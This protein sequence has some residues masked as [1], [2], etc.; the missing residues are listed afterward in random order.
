M[1]YDD[2]VNIDSRVPRPFKIIDGRKW[3]LADEEPWDDGE[4]EDLD[5]FQ[6]PPREVPFSVQLAL[7]FGSGVG[8]VFGTIFAGFALFIT[9]VVVCIVGLED[10]IPRRWE[11]AV[12]GKVVK[13]EKMNLEI[14]NVRYSRYHLEGTA[15]D[16]TVLRGS[17]RQPAGNHAEGDEVRM[18]HSGGHVRIEGTR[19]VYFIWIFIG[20]ALLFT[21]IGLGVSSFSMLSGLKRIRL[22]RDGTLS[23]A[24]II[25]SEPTNVRINH[26][27]VMKL[28][29][30]YTV[31]GQPYTA[32]FRT[33]EADRL[34]DSSAKIAF[35]D[36]LDP[37][38]ALLWESLPGIRVDEL[39]GRFQAGFAR[40]LL[41]M[42]LGLI[43]LAELAALLYFVAQAFV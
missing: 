24:H 23:T 10:A 5:R 30:Q 19:P 13:V 14:N 38:K 8:T 36:L 43:V 4:P 26:R 21:V 29:F 11:P 34:D 3:V 9:L 27:Q 39:T 37:N 32:T 31:D 28:T 20:M 15:P 42:L 17:V 6:P 7:L 41:P 35:Y 22:L 25:G 40:S 16:G 12:P 2:E 33:L 1:V 18:Q